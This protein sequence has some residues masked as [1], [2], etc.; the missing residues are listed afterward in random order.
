MHRICQDLER[1]QLSQD[2]SDNRPVTHEDTDMGFLIGAGH[3]SKRQNLV[4][5]LLNLAQD[6]CSKLCK[7]ALLTIMKIHFF[8]VDL[9]DQALQVDKKDRLFVNS[10]QQN[11]NWKF[12]AISS[13]Q[14][15]QLL[16]TVESKREYKKI[17]G[18]LPKLHH[19]L[20]LDSAEDDLLVI[21]QKIFPDSET[22]I[23][24]QNQQILYNL[25]D[26]QRISCVSG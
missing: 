20:S 7:M 23:D 19:H 3:R 4:Q 9:F 12:S 10:F 22:E 16:S 11:M 25:G 6:D 1:L 5:V 15:S 18:L 26:L 2:P 8:D 17:E 13:T 14:Q 21:L 24:P